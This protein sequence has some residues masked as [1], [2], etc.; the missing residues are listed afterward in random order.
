MKESRA[1]VV[2]T[3]GPASN[4]R[5]VLFQ[6]IKSGMDVA[7]LNFSHGSHESHQEVIGLIRAGSKK[8]I[9]LLKGK[10]VKKGDRI[11]IIAS[12]P[13]STKAKTNFMKL[14]QVGE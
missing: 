10:I 3:I 5:A 6:L 12:S 13:F 11:V 14:H 4:S 9:A 8:F 1:K 7:R 2:C